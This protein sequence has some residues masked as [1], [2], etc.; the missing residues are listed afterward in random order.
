[1]LSVREQ[2]L[3]FNIE[4]TEQLL[5]VKFTGST[6]KEKEAFFAKYSEQRVS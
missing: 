6:L 1:M 3:N 5:G 2:F 4:L